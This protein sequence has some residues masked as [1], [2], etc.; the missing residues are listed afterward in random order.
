MKMA[1]ATGSVHEAH[2]SQKFSFLI[3]SFFKEYALGVTMIF[4]G[5]SKS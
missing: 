4:W 3:L 2:E 1:Y 5:L